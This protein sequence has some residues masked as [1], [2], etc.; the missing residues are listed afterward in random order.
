M[1]P[2]MACCGSIYFFTCEKCGWLSALTD[3]MLKD[4]IKE[5]EKQ[6]EINPSV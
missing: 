3:K 4:L 6:K 5:Y 2:Q 1:K